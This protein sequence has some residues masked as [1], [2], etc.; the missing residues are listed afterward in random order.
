MSASGQRICR[1][2]EDAAAAPFPADAL[3]LVCELRLELEEF[4]RQQVARALTAGEPMSAIARALGISRQAAHNRFR[5]LTRSPRASAGS[6]RCATPE[7]RLVADY[8]R[9]EAAELGSA[10]VGVEHL[11]LGILRNGDERAASALEAAG[12]DLEAG[13]SHLRAAFAPTGDTRAALAEA[14][15]E[16][17]ARASECIG[18]EH[19]LRGCLRDPRGAAQAFL[20]ALGVTPR[21]VVAA[22]DAGPVRG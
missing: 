17:D 21:A 2:A 12:L 5:P 22:L 6:Q 10:T 4:E 1:L 16:A 19:L 13:R 11:L 14:A 9:R 20:A 15:R 7:T 8:A 3:R 18:V